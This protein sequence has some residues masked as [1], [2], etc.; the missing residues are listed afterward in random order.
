MLHAL[1]LGGGGGIPGLIRTNL[2]YTDQCFQFIVY[3]VHM[4]NE[5]LL[6]FRAR[7]LPSILHTNW[8]GGG[9]TCGESLHAARPLR[10]FIILLNAENSANPVPSPI[11]TWL[12]SRKADRK[13]MYTCFSAQACHGT[14]DPLSTSTI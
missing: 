8:G 13:E 11:Y 2:I 9:G 4:T 1:G 7:S 6:F 14:A 3:Q 10:P 12:P 5:P